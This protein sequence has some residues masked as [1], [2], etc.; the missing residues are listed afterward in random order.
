MNRSNLS[1]PANKLLNIKRNICNSIFYIHCSV[2]ISF[3]CLNAAHSTWPERA[4]QPRRISHVVKVSS[5]GVVASFTQPKLVLR[6]QRYRVADGRPPLRMA[7]SAWTSTHVPSVQL[8]LADPSEPPV[9]AGRFRRV[10]RC[11]CLHRRV[12]CANPR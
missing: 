12:L 11:R 6:L 9:S 3:A 1:T 7:P 10:P 8:S 5:Y 4:V 2:T